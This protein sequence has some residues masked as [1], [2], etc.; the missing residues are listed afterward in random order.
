M[1]IALP[2]PRKADGTGTMK[3]AFSYWD[4]RIAPVFDTARNILLL[5]SSSDETVARSE[6][7]L[8]GDDPAGKALRLAELGVGTLVC[9]AISR[10]VQE[11]VT[12]S[13]IAV[14]PFIAGELE[15]VIE[16]W[17]LGM[18]DRDTFAMP[19]CSHAR[20]GRGGCGRRHGYGAWYRESC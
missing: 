3:T 6:A 13:G 5:E 17:G 1:D 14:V 12:A 10:P 4:G 2:S 7:V 9:G 19:G 20:R 15:L 18:L 16:A 11:A 8:P